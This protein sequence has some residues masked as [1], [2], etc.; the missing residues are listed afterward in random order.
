MEEV[1]SLES[2]QLIFSLAFVQFLLTMLL[3]LHLGMVMYTLCH[4]MLEVCYV[5]FDFVFTE[6][7]SKGS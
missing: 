6:D 2:A 1:P 4:Y 7:Y 5:C 3:L